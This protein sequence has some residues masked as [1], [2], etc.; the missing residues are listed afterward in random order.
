MC[1]L[2]NRQYERRRSDFGT[3]CQACVWYSQMLAPSE[4]GEELND[5]IEVCVTPHG[6]LSL[7]H[8]LIVSAAM[9]PISI[10]N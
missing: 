1:T 8:I 10:L 6:S 9:E 5:A 3:V 4:T 2:V 7:T